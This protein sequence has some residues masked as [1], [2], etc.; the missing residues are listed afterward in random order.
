M[1][2]RKAQMPHMR[3]GVNVYNSE[4]FRTLPSVALKLW[5]DLRTQ[6]NG[7]N[8]GRICATLSALRKRGWNSN[9]VLYR[10]LAE[11]L[12]RGLLACTRRGKRGSA[13]VANLYRFT[14]LDCPKDDRVGVEGKQPTLEF[15]KW[16]PEAPAKAWNSPER[17]KNTAPSDGT[18]LHRLTV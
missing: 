3:I 4:A 15:L 18:T 1:K 6:N 12:D 9:D 8:N 11:L 14:D 5:I 10:A 7:F 16:Q 13:R 17:K 2:D